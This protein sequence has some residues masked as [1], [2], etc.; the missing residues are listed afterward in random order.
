MNL[1][2]KF[3]TKAIL[4]RLENIQI[5]EVNT[6]MNEAIYTEGFQ[7]KRVHDSPNVA[8]KEVLQLVLIKLEHVHVKFVTYSKLLLVLTTK[9]EKYSAEIELCCR[10]VQQGHAEINALKDYRRKRQI[11]R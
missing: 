10:D 1:K 3:L 2:G 9:A 7:G 4:K 11:S 6:G 5:I 8:F